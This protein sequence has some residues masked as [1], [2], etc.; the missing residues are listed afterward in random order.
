M[1]L[2]Y[3]VIMIIDTRLVPTKS[4]LQIFRRFSRQENVAT[5]KVDGRDSEKHTFLLHGIVNRTL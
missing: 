4:M 1:T 5:A 3:D 2:L